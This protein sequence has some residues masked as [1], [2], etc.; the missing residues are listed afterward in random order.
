L[1]VFKLKNIN[2][3]IIIGES[4]VIKKPIIDP[5]KVEYERLIDEKQNIV[6]EINNLK[7]QSQD[8]ISNAQKKADSILKQ[9]E[10]EKDKIYKEIEDVKIECENLKK[11]AQ[12][13]IKENS[14]EKYSKAYDDGFEKGVNDGEQ[15]GLKS[16]REQ[17][18]TV[19]QEA[20]RIANSVIEKKQEILVNSDKEILKIVFLIAKKV[21]NSELLINKEIVLNNIQAALARL[22]D[23]ANVT[24]HINKKDLNIIELKKEEFFNTIRGLK[25][26]NIIEENY[27]K[28]GD[29]IIETDYGFIDA[30]IDSQFE[31]LERQILEEGL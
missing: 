9:A 15:E 16:S 28:P 18:T 25:N 24:V 21:V 5:E 30:V 11:N 22:T 2:N 10:I 27:L 31:E 19:L 12:I 20:E 23:K 29:C 8:I 26:F 6:N 13:E 14:E 1:T 4:G 3:K 17:Y 7:S